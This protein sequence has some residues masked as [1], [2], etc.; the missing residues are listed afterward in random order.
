MQLQSS[1]TIVWSYGLLYTTLITAECFALWYHFSFG[2]AT[3]CCITWSIGPFPNFDLVCQ[4]VLFN[5]FACML[6]NAI[7]GL[8]HLFIAYTQPLIV[9]TTLASVNSI[10]RFFIGISIII[11]T[12]I[13]LELHH[14]IRTRTPIPGQGNLIFYP[15]ASLLYFYL[16]LLYNSHS[17][18]KSF[19]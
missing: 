1:L 11:I 7:A 2:R 15:V 18:N 12:I 17:I 14:S 13:V 16:F 8:E 19:C 3:I 4:Y 10:L 6:E 5:S 9:A